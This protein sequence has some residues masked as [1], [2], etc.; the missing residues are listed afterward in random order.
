MDI[1]TLFDVLHGS[2]P[3]HQKNKSYFYQ[4]KEIINI[5]EKKT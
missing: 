2:S 1:V 5:E 3:H 4:A